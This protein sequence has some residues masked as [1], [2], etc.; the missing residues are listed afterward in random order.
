MSDNKLYWLWITLKDKLSY[1]DIEKLINKFGNPLNVYD[2][3]DVKELKEFSNKIKEQ[4]MDKSLD[5]AVSVYK[6]TEE[7]DSRVVTIEDDEYPPLLRHIDEPP[8]VLYMYGERMDWE[9]LLTITIV[10]TRK[11]NVYGKNVTQRLSYDLAKAGVV[12]VSG[13]ARGIDSIAGVT[14]LNSGNK[15]VAVL[16]SGFDKVYPPEKKNLFYQIAKNGVVITEYPPDMKAFPQNF[17][18]RNRIMAGLSYGAV[19][20]QAPRRSGAIITASRALEYG[21]DVFAVPGGMFS[22]G[23]QGCNDLIR[24]GAKL[25][26]SYMDIIN[27][28]PY[29]EPNCPSEDNTVESSFE[30]VSKINFDNYN[31]NQQKIIRILLQGQCHIDEMTRQVDFDSGVLSTELLMLE[32]NGAVNKLDGN[33]YEL[34]I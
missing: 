19:V 18:R 21:R 1:N 27:E 30:R 13:M 8:Y 31:Q 28:Y 11:F 6:R 4:I 5:R 32:L 23:S 2:I 33:I 20:T 9:K 26:T 25:V 7:L 17:P 3:E 10:G 16:G 15:T 34:T 24:E 14:A 29:F 22:P 12:I